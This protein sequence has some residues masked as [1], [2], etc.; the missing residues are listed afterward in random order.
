LQ[1]ADGE[2]ASIYA[3]AVETVRD[4][5]AGRLALAIALPSHR[6]TWT[7]LAQ[8]MDGLGYVNT[9]EMPPLFLEPIVSA[10]GLGADPPGGLGDFDETWR[11]LHNVEMPMVDDPREK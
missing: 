11:L 3:L 8:E 5:A 1:F 7:M 2:T 4:L 9:A 6:E 10:L